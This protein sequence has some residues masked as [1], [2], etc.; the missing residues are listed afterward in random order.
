MEGNTKASQKDIHTIVE[1][2]NIIMSRKLE[3]KNQ[4]QSKN[5]GVKEIKT[6]FVSLIDFHLQDRTRPLLKVDIRFNISSKIKLQIS[7]QFQ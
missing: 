4:G 2:R 6:V 1:H 7:G 5:K 3:K